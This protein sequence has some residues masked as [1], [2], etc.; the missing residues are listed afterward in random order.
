VELFIDTA[1]IDEVR[2]AVALGVI[3]GCTTNPK[4]AASAGPGN[5]RARVEGYWPAVRVR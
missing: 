1:D 5:F 3:S 2:K 4:L